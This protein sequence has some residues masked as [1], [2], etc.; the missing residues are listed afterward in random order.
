[1]GWGSSMPRWSGPDDVRSCGASL[2]DSRASNAAKN[3]A[4]LWSNVG[5]MLSTPYMSDAASSI[6]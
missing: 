2:F 1:M 6:Q 4:R 3:T 5:P